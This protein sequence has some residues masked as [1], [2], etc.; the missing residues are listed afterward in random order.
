[1]G[2]SWIQNTLCSQDI[3]TSAGEVIPP[4]GFPGKVIVPDLLDGA[5]AWGSPWAW[6]SAPPWHQRH[7]RPLTLPRTQHH[8]AS[9][10]LPHLTRNFP[11]ILFHLMRFFGFLLKSF[12]PSLRCAVVT[13]NLVKDPFSER[14]AQ[15]CWINRGMKKPETKGEHSHLESW[16]KLSQQDQAPPP[17]LRQE[18]GG[19]ILYF[20]R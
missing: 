19:F 16:G 4:P 6:A 11:C 17:G 13:A 12:S 2:H 5:G 3:K 14:A 7:P 20:K 10:S 1:M 9:L 8:S 18:L 15:I